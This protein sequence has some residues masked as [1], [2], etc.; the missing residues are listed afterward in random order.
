MNV[1]FHT[2][3][4]LGIA[5]LLTDTNRIEQSISYRTIA[6]TGFAAFIVALV[7]H[8]ALDYIPHCYPVNSKLDV[9]GG[10]LI[11]LTL[12][13]LTKG[14]YR[15]ITALSFLGSIFPDLVDLSPAIL[16]KQIG[17]EL[18]IFDQLFPWHWHENSGSI[19]SSNCNV[20]TFNHMILVL[21]IAVICWCRRTDLKVLFN[22]R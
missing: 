6:F 8:A 18:P 21:S 15:L 12:T 11:I 9:I 20:S 19:Y 4:A 7:S 5:V 10:L 16:N 14:K 13:W 2:T 22:K 3:T 1:I 17:L